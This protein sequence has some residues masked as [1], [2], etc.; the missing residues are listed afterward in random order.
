[1]TPDRASIR[2]DGQGPG[3][4]RFF[5]DP[6]EPPQAPPRPA[7]LPNRAQRERAPRS[8]LRPRFRLH[9]AGTDG[10][11]SLAAYSVTRLGSLH[12]GA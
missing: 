11:R 3:W 12:F 6:R 9:P 1:M 8:A 2:R 5:G 4:R 7:R 10:A